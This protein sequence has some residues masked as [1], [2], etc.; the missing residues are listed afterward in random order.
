MKTHT[1]TDLTLASEWHAKFV[2]REPV[3]LDGVKYLIDTASSTYAPDFKGLECGLTPCAEVLDLSNPP[4]GATHYHPRDLRHPFRKKL[5]DLCFAWRTDDSSWVQIKNKWAKNSWEPLPKAAQW[6]GEG[7]PPVG[8]DCEFRSEADGEYWCPAKVTHI[9]THWVLFTY[10]HP[11]NGAEEAGVNYQKLGNRLTDY[12]RP[13]KTAEQLAAE[14]REAEVR[15]IAVKVNVVLPVA[16]RI[17]DA[18][19]RFPE[20]K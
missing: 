12:L 10:T 7:L 4:A 13:I 8:V 9:G 6:D 11:K 15:L 18:G 3:Y 1:I 16:E 19:L 2:A 5:A 20:E 17:Y 14:Q